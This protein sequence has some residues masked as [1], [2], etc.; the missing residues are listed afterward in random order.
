M[1]AEDNR[2]ENLRRLVD[3]LA[4][5]AGGKLR[6]GYR[7]IATATGLDEEYIYQLYSGRK[8]AM[9]ADAAKA[10]ARAFR[11]G[12]PEGWFD[13]PPVDQRTEANVTSGPT[14]HGPYPLISEVQAGGW[15][16][17]CDNFAPGDA[18]DWMI[19]T[20][21]LGEC[22]FL[23][24]VKGRSMENPGGRY[25]FP[26]GMILHVNPELEPVPSQFVV[27]RR[28][29]TKEAT[30]KRYVLIDGEKYLEAINPD[31]PRDQKYLKLQ[32]GDTWCGVV[33][34]ASLGGL[35]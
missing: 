20:K 11:H 25:H 27:V 35:P 32:K 19:S 22:G 16:E 10:I 3:E 30:F 26:E 28:E 17:L 33:V 6:Q 8:K 23:L 1:T 18:E 12:R 15:T 14:S 7:A 34:D 21:N 31:W 9:G 5:E 24:R 13:R 2:M 4:A 29:S